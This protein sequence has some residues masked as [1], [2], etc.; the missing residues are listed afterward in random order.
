MSTA[1]E[2][3]PRI[4]PHITVTPIAGDGVFFVSQRGADVFSGPLFESLVPLLNGKRTE[5]EIL[6]QL[7]GR[8]ALPEA[9]Y[10]L[11]ILDRAGYI[12]DAEAFAELDG[13]YRSLF[14]RPRRPL[15]VAVDNLSSA[16]LPALGAALASQGMIAANAPELRLV[17]VDDYL[18]GR[19]DAINAQALESGLP[20]MLA[21]PAA[22]VLWIGPIFEPHQSGCWKCLTERLSLNQPVQRY[23]DGKT[24]VASTPHAVRSPALQDLATSL[25]INELARW[26]SAESDVAELLAFDPVTN[27][28]YRHALVRRPQCTYCGAKIT[29]DPAEMLAP[30]VGTTLANR[31]GGLR[32]E[33]ASQTYE[34]LKHHVSDVTG[35][36]S[37]LT[38]LET[39]DDRIHVY[40][41]GQ[42]FAATRGSLAILGRSLRSQ[43]SGKGIT[44]AQAKASALCEGIERYASVF[45]GYEPTHRASLNE[46]GDKAIH[47]NAC[48]LFSQAQYDNRMVWNARGDHF[49]WVP[50]RMDP[51]EKLLWSPVWDIATHAERYLPS[52][53]LYFHSEKLLDPAGMEVCTVDSNG[54]AAGRSYSEAILQG[55]FE[56][57]ERDAVALWWYPRTEAPGVDLASFRSDY[58]SD[59][60]NYHRAR[61]RDL[62]VLDVTSDLGIPTFVAVSRRQSDRGRIALG[63]GAH[64]DA[65]TAISRAIGE[66]NQ[67]LGG[68]ERWT[69]PRPAFDDGTSKWIGSATT[70]REPYLLASSRLPP[71]TPDTHSRFDLDVQGALD[72]CGGLLRA[73][74]VDVLVSDLTRPDVDLKVVKVI[75]PGLR[76]F[77][78]R[79]AP[80]RLYTTPVALQRVAVP[81][82]EDQLNST[83]MFL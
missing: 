3:R 10:A 76:H 16:P 21:R 36:V 62:W 71:T 41:A 66:L 8:H 32:M 39:D 24:G 37:R 75:A 20:W 26:A 55:L 72:H 80:G 78:A 58:Y 15:R 82:P 77:W 42:N 49:S 83:P 40:L 17:L 34:R 53:H 73:A 74:G 22:S 44:E 45:Q 57:V 52:A 50:R 81:V 18:D 30:L 48:M 65:K 38:R 28:S 23:I 4:P 67:F 11:N 43:S 46:L 64:L 35:V 12:E 63:F 7:S 69:P 1:P 47:P 29:I 25:L 13:E 5:R 6:D 51:D 68:V 33:T 54:H 61:G 19:L 60:L 9:L 14:G 31:D 2:A 27:A 56:L 79:F 70:D 59:C